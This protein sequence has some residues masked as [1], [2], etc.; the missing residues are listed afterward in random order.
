MSHHCNPCF[1]AY[2]S[3]TASCSHLIT[4][5]VTSHNADFSQIMAT[6]RHFI[7]VE[8]QYDMLMNAM[9]TCS[10]VAA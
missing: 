9:F 5:H 10:N 7:I 8:H 1:G 4:L 3:T 6:P 2:S